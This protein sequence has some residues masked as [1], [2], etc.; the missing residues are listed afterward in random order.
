MPLIIIGSQGNV[1]RRLMAAFPGAIGIDRV[2]GADIVAD[3]AT[4]DY[5]ETDVRAAFEKADGV[6]HV[7]T[8]PNVQAPDSVHWE[9]VVGAARLMHACDRFGIKRVVLPSSDW[10]EPKTRWADN[11]QNAYG[12]SK[13]IMEEMA[14]MYNMTP[15]R[16]CVALRI[17][18]VVHDPAIVAGAADWLKANIWD[19]ER[20]IGQMKAAL[21]GQT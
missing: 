7:A 6:I 18:W 15:G 19:D 3:I 17:G 4:I 13:R 21:G 16:M 20:L 11:E 14:L 2:P 8:S 12:R 5:D 1:G 10:A 9:A